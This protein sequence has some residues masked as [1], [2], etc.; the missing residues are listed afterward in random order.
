MAINKFSNLHIRNYASN[1]QKIFTK[2]FLITSMV[3]KSWCLAHLKMQPVLNLTA[4]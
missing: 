2:P 4:F 1:Y 3:A